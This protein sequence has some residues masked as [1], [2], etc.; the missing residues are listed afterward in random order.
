MHCFYHV[1]VKV[2]YEVLGMSH[3][4]LAPLRRKWNL[5]RWPFADICRGAFKIDG[6]Y[7]TWDDIENKRKEMLALPD[8]DIRIVKIL[9]VMGE[10]ARFHKHKVNWVIANERKQQQNETKIACEQ[11]RYEKVQENGILSEQYDAPPPPAN[12]D[13][14]EPADTLILTDEEWL[15]SFSQLLAAELDAPVGELFP[16]LFQ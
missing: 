10:R 13:Q 3:H 9:D 8:I 1:P 6:I 15:E 7:V 2:V 14:P 12:A 5:R 11:A 16:P 4:T